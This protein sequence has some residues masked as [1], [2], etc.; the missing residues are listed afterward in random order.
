MGIIRNG[1]KKLAAMFSYLNLMGVSSPAY[2]SNAQN[3]AGLEI[4]AI[5]DIYNTI[6]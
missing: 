4:N 3:L 2:V 5:Q 6:Q 1:D